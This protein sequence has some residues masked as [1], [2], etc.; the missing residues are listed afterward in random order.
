MPSSNVK[1]FC[2]RLVIR[3]VYPIWKYFLSVRNN[4]GL[5][6][7]PQMTVTNSI[8]VKSVVMI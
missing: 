3:N 8:V 5:I 7:K 1:M 2:N 6:Q 4:K